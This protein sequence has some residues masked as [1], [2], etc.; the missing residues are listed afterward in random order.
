MMFL[1]VR[2]E[3]LPYL[4]HASAPSYRSALA[5]L[6]EPRYVRYRFEK[7]PDRIGTAEI[8][9]ERRN[10]AT[11]VRTRVSLDDLPVAAGGAVIRIGPLNSALDV[12]LDA[13]LRL[14]RFQASSSAA[15]RHPVL[16]AMWVSMRAQGE[17][18]DGTLHV[19]AWLGELERSAAVP[20]PAG[21]TL[22]DQFTPV[23]GGPGLEVGKRWSRKVLSFDPVSGGFALADEYLTVVERLTREW[24]GRIVD[25][26]VVYVRRDPTKDVPDSTVYVLPDGRVIEQ[27]F[28]LLNVNLT[29][30]LEE[31]R[32]GAPEDRQSLR[33]EGWTREH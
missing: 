2:E 31:D 5:D 3:V 24:E 19:R 12:E 13:A 15:T 30:I 17:Q 1:L 20:F 18:R 10:L 29:A 9:M 23:L 16:G 8:L 21:A 22:G 26:F 7:G 11:F 28:T 32:R 25:C 27:S 4:Q 6:D 14:R 33:P